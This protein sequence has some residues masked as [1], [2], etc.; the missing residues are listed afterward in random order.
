MGRWGFGLFEGD[1]DLDEVM[2]MSS[3]AGFE[4]YHYE[5]PQDSEDDVFRGIGLEATRNRLNDG[6]LTRL[7]AKYTTEPIPEL[8][9]DS[10]KKLRLILLGMQNKNL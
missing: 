5:R 6:V 1:H 2:C 8:D 7:F 9:N 4:L 3:D 10:D